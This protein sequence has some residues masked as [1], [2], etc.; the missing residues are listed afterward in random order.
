MI[1]FRCLCVFPKGPGMC[2]SSFVT[3]RC[4]AP[5]FLL[6][7][8]CSLNPELPRHIS[9]SHLLLEEGGF[10]PSSAAG[11][12]LE[13]DLQVVLGLKQPR[14]LLSQVCICLCFVTEE[15]NTGHGSPDLVLEEESDVQV[16]GDLGY[17]RVGGVRILTRFPA[18]RSGY[19]H[20]LPPPMVQLLCISYSQAQEILQWTDWL[21][22]WVWY[23]F[24]TAEILQKDFWFSIQLGFTLILVLNNSVSLWFSIG[25]LQTDWEKHSLSHHTSSLETFTFTPFLMN[26]AFMP[27]ADLETTI[28]L[29]LTSTFLVFWR[30]SLLTR[31]RFTSED[32]DG[33]PKAI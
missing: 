5:A 10:L 16:R 21:T 7:P 27:H 24:A 9:C 20:P 30:M 8:S 33:N 31:L 15:A 13:V 17:W 3:S 26:S 19:Q 4:S 28:Y 12:F 23:C 29:F 1:H 25:N 22:S 11:G 2:T 14:Q 32:E 6:H 18:K